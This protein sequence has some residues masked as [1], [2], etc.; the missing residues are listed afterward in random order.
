M[1]EYVEDE[2]DILI[3]HLG[4]NNK[5]C[6]LLEVIDTSHPM[7]P[8]DFSSEDHCRNIGEDCN[9]EKC[10]FKVGELRKV[11]VKIGY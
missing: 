4:G 10:P 9:Y 8:W 11:N 1:P 7:D 6:V 2:W 3:G 5:L